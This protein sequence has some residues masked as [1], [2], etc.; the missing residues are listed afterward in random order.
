LKKGEE[1]RKPWAL[2]W[3]EE[4]RAG[5]QQI[6]LVHFQLMNHHR[7]ALSDFVRLNRIP[8]LLD[9]DLSALDVFGESIE[10]DAVQ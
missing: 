7:S 2:K 1:Q 5:I 9:M 10:S 8:L 6:G 3:F 4:V